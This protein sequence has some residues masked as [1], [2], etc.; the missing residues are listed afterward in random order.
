MHWTTVG[1]ATAADSLILDYAASH[2]FVLFTHDLD[3]GMLL[4]LRK[5]RV[6]SRDPDY[7]VMEY[8]EGP[9]LAERIE[10]RPAFHGRFC[11][12]LNYS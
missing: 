11:K 3:F 12:V 7:L 1:K 5:A 8:V 2:G 6:P 10:A 9:T 4:A